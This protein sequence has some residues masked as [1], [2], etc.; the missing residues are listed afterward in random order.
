M[1]ARVTSA[2]VRI[3]M[4]DKF[5]DIFKNSIIPAAKKQKGYCG[6]YLF[7]DRKTGRG[8]A[9]TLWEREEFAISN[10]ETMY[11]QEQLIKIHVLLSK[12]PIRDGYEVVASDL[13]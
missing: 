11:Y 6:A 7:V 2:T 4:I 13:I 3:E 5:I 1:F 12:N 10:E 9:V 8:K